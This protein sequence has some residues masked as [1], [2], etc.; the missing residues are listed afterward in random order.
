MAVPQLL[1]TTAHR[2]DEALVT[3]AHTVADRCGVQATRR[4]RG[5]A[6]HL[7]E[8]GASLAYVVGRG[9]DWLATAR[10]RLRIDVG[11]LHAHH[12]QGPRHPLIR[13]I[14]PAQHIADATLGMC[15]DA[16]HVAS[17]TGARVTGFEISPPLFSLAERGLA[18]LASEGLA[19]AGQITPL[20]GDARQLLASARDVDVVML[21]PMFDRPRSAPPG[22][23]LLR[24]VAHPAP[25]DP[26]WLHAALQ[27][28][29]RVVVK[30]RRTQPVPAFAVP[31]LQQILRSKAIDHWV[32]GR[33]P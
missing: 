10:A 26:G 27:V 1:V 33:I 32:L 5:L 24:H 31:H 28:A 17:V 22:F 21:S 20:W 8:A 13:A 2:P 12:D 6:R 29:P 11:L 30:A 19:A 3:R 14:G 15:H 4:T 25:L 9:E 18:R 16:L 7:Q 23:E